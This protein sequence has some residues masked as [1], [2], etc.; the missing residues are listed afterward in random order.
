MKV[1]GALILLSHFSL[2]A[3]AANELNQSFSK[4]KKL[5]ETKVYQN[6]RTTLY[7]GASFD[8]KKNIKPPKGS[9]T[10]KAC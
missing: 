9:H 4:A 8:S 3:F 6:N 5:L 1:I 10:D 7:C 2:S